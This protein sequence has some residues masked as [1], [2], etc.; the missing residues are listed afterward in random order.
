MKLKTACTPHLVRSDHASGD[1]PLEHIPGRD[2]AMVVG[3]HNPLRVHREVVGLVGLAPQLRYGRHVCPSLYGV[4]GVRARARPDAGA[5]QQVHLRR[6]SK[7][8][9]N[10]ALLPRPAPVPHAL[11]L[12]LPVLIVSEV[13]TPNQ[14]IQSECVCSYLE[15][16]V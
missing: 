3:Q 12:L 11:L 1:H 10:G 14:H 6:V 8:V 9:P 4:Q 2:I 15:L 5:S 13:K 7:H 16:V